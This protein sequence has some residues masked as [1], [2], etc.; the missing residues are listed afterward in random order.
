[1]AGLEAARAWGRRGSRKL[2]M[3]EK[4]ITLASKL[5]HD[6]ETLIAEVCE[7]T[8]VSKATIYRY[9]NPDGTTRPREGSDLQA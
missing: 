3:D 7:A 6:W 8:G 2:A 4:K 9:M 1:M 5:M